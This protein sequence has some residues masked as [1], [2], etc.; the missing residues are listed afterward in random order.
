MNC[1]FSFERTVS[2]PEI[3]H[4]FSPGDARDN[5]GNSHHCRDFD[6]RRHPK[7]KSAR[8]RAAARPRPTRSTSRRSLGGTTAGAGI[9][10]RLGLVV[11]D[12]F[13]RAG[14]S[15]GWTRSPARPRN[16]LRAAFGDVSAD[17][18]LT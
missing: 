3:S 16:S 13:S 10:D 5:A 11:G 15:P 9:T 18:P 8:R 6:Q 7:E 4:G 17:F 12:P 2:F 1:F 14:L